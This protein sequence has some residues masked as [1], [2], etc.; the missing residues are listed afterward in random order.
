MLNLRATHC[1]PSQMSDAKGEF[2]SDVPFELPYKDASDL[3]ELDESEVENTIIKHLKGKNPTPMGMAYIRFIQRQMLAI[4]QHTKGRLA[5]SKRKVFKDGEWDTPRFQEI[6]KRQAA[7]LYPSQDS[8]ATMLLQLLYTGI[9]QAE[10]LLYLLLKAEQE[11]WSS[12]ARLMRIVYSEKESV[13]VRCKVLVLLVKELKGQPL[14]WFSIEELLF[15]ECNGLLLS[16]TEEKKA[17]DIT[18][19]RANA[20]RSVILQRPLN[21]NPIDQMPLII[22][23]FAVKLDNRK[24]TEESLIEQVADVVSDCMYHVRKTDPNYRTAVS[25]TTSIVVLKRVK[26]GLEFEEGAAN[27][28]TDAQNRIAEAFAVLFKEN[29]H[30]EHNE[31]WHCLT[32][33]VEQ[34]AKWRTVNSSATDDYLNSSWPLEQRKN[35]AFSD[36]LGAPLSSDKTKALVW[37]PAMPVTFTAEQLSVAMEDLRLPRQEMK[38]HVFDEYQTWRPKPS[39]NVSDLV[40]PFKKKWFHETL[41]NRALDF[42]NEYGFAISEFEK[43]VVSKD[44]KFNDSVDAMIRSIYKVMYPDMKEVD[45]VDVKTFWKSFAKLRER[46]KEAAASSKKG[47]ESDD[48]EV[49]TEEVADDDDDDDEDGRVSRAKKKSKKS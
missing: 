17:Y 7:L 3:V 26:N 4:N 31:S 10:R 41:T 47:P 38:K 22:V 27:V 48:E 39:G 23:E 6:V 34:S 45:K 25:N 11:G 29:G 35:S 49:Y 2:P 21:L 9:T 30:G 19:Q 36:T 8:K 28:V 1:V 32:V 42:K 43:A 24:K 5:K 12:D 18:I 15:P 14:H 46:A 16:E 40:M 37:F 44:S 20:L 33:S 13:E